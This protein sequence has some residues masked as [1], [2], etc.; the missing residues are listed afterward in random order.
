[1]SKIILLIFFKIVLIIGRLKSG[2][3]LNRKPVLLS[4]TEEEKKLYRLTK[5]NTLVNRDIPHK[6]EGYLKNARPKYEEIYGNKG[7]KFCQE[8]PKDEHKD[9]KNSGRVRFSSIVEYS[10]N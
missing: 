1:M 3:S 7:T 2:K 6:E 4:L 8:E 5:S 10:R 9:S